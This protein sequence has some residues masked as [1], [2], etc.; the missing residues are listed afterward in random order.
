MYCR[1][2]HP[3]VVCFVNHLNET[4]N[5]KYKQTKVAIPSRELLIYLLTD[6]TTE[7][8]GCIRISRCAFSRVFAAVPTRFFHN[9]ITV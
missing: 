8:F 3:S 7:N 5:G 2:C 6:F 1:I 9:F 4:H